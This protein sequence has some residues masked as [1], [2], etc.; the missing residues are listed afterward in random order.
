MAL[1]TCVAALLRD[2][3][4]EIDPSQSLKWALLPEV[5]PKSGVDLLSCRRREG[6]PADGLYP[7][8]VEL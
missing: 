6:K 2:F 7:S 4:F 1:K 5:R 8:I 3:E